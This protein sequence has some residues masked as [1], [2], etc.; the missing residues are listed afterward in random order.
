MRF[1]TKL[2]PSQ[3]GNIGKLELNNPTT[4]NAL[5]LDMVRSMNDILP[6]YSKTLKAT[7]LSSSSSSSNTKR[8]V[9]CSGGDMKSVYMAGMGLN[10]IKEDSNAYNTSQHGFGS[11]LLYTSSFF[12][13]EYELN[14]KIA[15]MTSS[16]SSSSSS[17]SPLI[18]IWDG[19]V[20][21][22]GVG[23]SIHGKYRIATENTIFAMP[24]TNIGFFPDVG[25]TYFLSKLQHG[26]LGT[27]I[28]LTGCRLYSNDLL[29]SGL[30]THYI[31]SEYIPEMISQLEKKSME[32]V[33]TT[34]NNT[35][36]STTH[37][38]DC[39]SSILM[40]FHEDPGQHNSFLA[41]NRKVIDETFHNKESIEDI[42]SSLEELKTKNDD[43]NNNDFC[44]KTLHTLSKMSPTSL[45]VTLEGMKRGK[46]LSN[47][48][49]SLKMEYRMS[50]AF[51][52]K[53]SD[54]Y[55][56][57]RAL[58]VDKDHIPKWNPSTLEEV[59]T[60]IVESYFNHLGEEELVF[61]MEKDS[62][63]KL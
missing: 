12:K 23:I 42:I 52:K 36:T 16:S 29:Y 58:L 27:Y 4:L 41:K 2:I 15:M 1:T 37:N 21:G 19:I 35:T 50:Q 60:D 39:V 43:N 53:D 48:T 61:D 31:K 34:D 33:M 49:E 11:S 44:S 63:S 28:G 3:S 59:T 57:I 46:E 32:V 7:I 26:G 40:S 38:R 25:S 10:G 13:E 6:T 9:F 62:T 54:F 55:E 47:I 22:G 17:S 24:E 5:D 20:M 18:S 8:K 45:K 30:A 56:G 51:M 14:H